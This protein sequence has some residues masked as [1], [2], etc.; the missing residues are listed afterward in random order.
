VRSCSL[1]RLKPNKLTY[2]RGCKNPRRLGFAV[3]IKIQQYL[4][5]IKN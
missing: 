2:R 3:M 1:L 4:K 5:E